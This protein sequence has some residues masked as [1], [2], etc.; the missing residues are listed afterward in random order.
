MRQNGPFSWAQSHM[1]NI[2]NEGLL[3]KIAVQK[4]DIIN[5]TGGNPK[6]FSH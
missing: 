5:L 6:F 3:V 1:T 4:M 2:L